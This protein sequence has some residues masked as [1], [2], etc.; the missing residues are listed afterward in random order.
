MNR[1]TM[2][3]ETPSFLEKKMIP[4]RP[5]ALKDADDATLKGPKYAATPL[6][7]DTE[8]ANFFRTPGRDT[9]LD[10]V[11]KDFSRQLAARESGSTVVG[12][13]APSTFSPSV[14]DSISSQSSI[15]SPDSEQAK[16]SLAQQREQYLQLKAEVESME[17]SLGNESE[18]ISVESARKWSE[19][20][21][22]VLVKKAE[23]KELGDII[24]KQVKN[25][26][27]N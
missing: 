19:T 1:T 8:A 11:G 3:P 16:F 25:K 24:L 5:I 20:N 13:E 9:A 10:H 22:A 17:A 27:V 21:K 26:T 4:E 12:T 14:P 7:S 15:P 6:A 2:S 23:L 18:E